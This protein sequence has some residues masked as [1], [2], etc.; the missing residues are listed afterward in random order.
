[1]RPMSLGLAGGVLWGASMFL[2]T[3]LAMWCNYGMAWMVMMGDLYP[4][5]SISMMGSFVGLFWGFIDGFIALYILAW[6]YNY[7]GE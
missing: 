6:L 4:G 3:Y 7:F 1:M 5:Y 2:M